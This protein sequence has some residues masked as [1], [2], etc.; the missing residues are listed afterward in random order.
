MTTVRNDISAAVRGTSSAGPDMIKAGPAV[1]GGKGVRMSRRL[2]REISY[3][4]KIEPA[5]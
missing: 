1:G 4:A 5:V 2:G 3:G